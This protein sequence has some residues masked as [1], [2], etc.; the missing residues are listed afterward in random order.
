MGQ[1]IKALV[2]EQWD[3][4]LTIDTIDFNWTSPS[5]LRGLELRDAA[6][7]EWLRAGSLK[8][9]LR[10][11]PGL[12]PVLSEIEVVDLD[13]QGHFVGGKLQLPLKLVSPTKQNGN[14]LIDIHSIMIRNISVGINV[15]GHSISTWQD[16]ELAIISDG[17]NYQIDL[18]G[19]TG[20]VEEEVFVTGT[21]EVKT[22]EANLNVVIKHIILHEEAAAIFAVMS[23]QSVTLAEGK[24]YMNVNLRGRLS[25]LP[26]DFSN[27]TLSGAFSLAD[28]SISCAKGPF[29]SD[30]R[31]EMRFDGQT[32]SSANAEWSASFCKGKTIGKLS[33]NIMDDRTVKYSCKVNMQGVNFNEMSKLLSDSH[34]SR[35]GEL[36][37]IYVISGRTGT[38]EETKERGYMCLTDAH[39]ADVPLLSSLFDFVGISQADAIQ[40]TDVEAAFTMDGHVVTLSNA[41][42]ANAVVAIDIEPG[43]QVEIEKTLSRF[44]CDCGSHQAGE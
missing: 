12:H 14:A 39:L 38:P 24:I 6:G 33:A 7:R 35:Q 1:R 16:F 17:Q 41:R 21:V 19:E 5:Y 10:D 32:P 31:G 2:H 30:L 4:E 26:A 29:L 27:I 28:G 11:W 44:I 36:Q 34:E 25:D 22:L 8:V 42:M 18:K 23:A 3:G 43:G 37:F 13:L 9:T 20:L 40:A 15:D